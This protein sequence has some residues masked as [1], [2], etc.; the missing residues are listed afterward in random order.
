MISCEIFVCNDFDVSGIFVNVSGKKTVI[1]SEGAK[2]TEVE[3]SE[4]QLFSHKSDPSTPFHYAQDDITERYSILLRH[5]S[6]TFC[7]Y[8]PSSNDGEGFLSS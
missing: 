7:T 5:F 2:C 8:A 1:L 3:E 6:I 4:R